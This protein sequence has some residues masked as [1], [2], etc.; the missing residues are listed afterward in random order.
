MKYANKLVSTLAAFSLLFMIA[1][2]GGDDNPTPGPGGD[3]GDG[4]G[5]PGAAIT[6]TWVQNEPD[7][8]TVPNDAGVTFTDFSITIG[9]TSTEGQLE[10]S[11]QNTEPLV[12]PNSGTFALPDTPNFTSG[13]Q[14]TREDNVP[15]TI[16]LV[17]EDQLRMVFTV[18]ADSGIPAD[19]SRVTQVSGE[20]TFLL[21]RDTQ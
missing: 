12:F 8:V 7:D 21:D 19:N 9:T 2:G 20:Y 4:G 16:T 3:D 17:G 1:C 10:Y 14:V 15:V 13:A 18:D 5:V 6:G 11:T